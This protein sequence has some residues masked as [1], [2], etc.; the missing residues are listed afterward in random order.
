M[1]NGNRFHFLQQDKSARHAYAEGI[2]RA[3]DAALSREWTDE[4]LREWKRRILE[5]SLSPSALC[6]YPPSPDASVELPWQFNADPPPE[7]KE[8]VEFRAFQ[9]WRRKHDVG[10]GDELN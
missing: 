4:Q 7:T 9:S 2:H 6:D 8:Q 5:W 1:L 10:G 3:V